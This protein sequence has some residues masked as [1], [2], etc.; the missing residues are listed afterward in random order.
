MKKSLKA[1]YGRKWTKRSKSW[2]KTINIHTYDLQLSYN[3]TGCVFVGLRSLSFRSIQVSIFWW[4][5]WR[6]SNSAMTL[7]LLFFFKRLLPM[8]AWHSN[9]LTIKFRKSGIPHH[10]P[11]QSGSFS[12][13]C[14]Y[15]RPWDV[16]DHTLQG[17]W[18][19][20]KAG[21][22]WTSVGD[23]SGLSRSFHCLHTKTFSDHL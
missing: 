2:E 1:W 9:D 10:P 17:N 4:P 11:Y 16:F 12:Q 20:S 13:S 5:T 19:G 3:T 15:L 8:C 22:S 14:E 18:G 7:C 21:S 6:P 23:G